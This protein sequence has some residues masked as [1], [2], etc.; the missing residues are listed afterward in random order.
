VL[1]AH[2]RGFCS[3][4]HVHAESVRTAV[5]C[6]NDAAA[7]VYV[8]L[9][10]AP[11][12][13]GNNL[14]SVSDELAYP[15]PL[16]LF[17]FDCAEMAVG[18][19]CGTIDVLL[20]AVDWSRYP[21]PRAF[22]SY[23][24]HTVEVV[25]AVVPAHIT[26]SSSSSAGAAADSKQPSASQVPSV[27]GSA[28]KAVRVCVFAKASEEVEGAAFA[29]TSSSFGAEEQAKLSA[30]LVSSLASIPACLHADAHARR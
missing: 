17:V 6:P 1:Q 16:L 3:L 2:G 20:S 26:A 5:N 18:E 30:L 19:L 10:L 25:D 11:N 8:D 15:L 23:H 29:S 21:L 12:F 28:G 13:D 22:S 14:P 9:A 4:F 27:N 24:S 7:F